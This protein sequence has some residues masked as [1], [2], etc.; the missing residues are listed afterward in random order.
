MTAAEFWP[1]LWAKTGKKIPL[2]DCGLGCS[3]SPKWGYFPAFWPKLLELDLE[4]V[5]GSLLPALDCWVSS[6]MK[7]GAG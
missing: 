2:W 1:W 6:K 5:S 3:G 4:P 7:S